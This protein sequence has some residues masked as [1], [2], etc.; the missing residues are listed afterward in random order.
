MLSS[1]KLR[2]LL[3]KLG[4]SA[5]DLATMFIESELTIRE[6]CD[7]LRLKVDIARETALEKI[8]KESN[9]LMSEIDAYEHECWSSW[10]AAKEST[11]VIVEDV[12]KRMRAFLA[13]QHAYLQSV[14]SSDEELTALHLDEASKLAQEL[15]DR[16]KELKAAMFNDKLASFITF[17]SMAEASLLGELSFT[18]I[19]LPFKKLDISTSGLKAVDNRAHFDFLLPLEHGER[20]VAFEFCNK[21]EDNEN[22][23][24]KVTC[25]DRLIRTSRQVRIVSGRVHRRNV[26]QCGPS[27][28][29]VC[30]SKD[31]PELIV[32]DSDLNCLRNVRCK[33]FR[34]I[35]C[36]SKFVFGLWEAINETDSEKEEFSTDRIQVLHLDTLSEAFELRALKKYGMFG[37]VTDE[38]HLIAIGLKDID[39]LPWFMSIFDLA[40][41]NESGGDNSR[42]E[43]TA[44]KFFL[45]ERYVD[46]GTQWLWR[47]EAFLLDGWLVV[48]GENRSTFAWF[49]K[50]GKRSETSTDVDLGNVRAIYWSGGSSLLF[51][52]DDDKLLLKRF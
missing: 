12:R 13:E 52:F 19:T 42:G 9:T 15:S 23:F 18:D 29:V 48:P 31:S 17:T 5:S 21:R 32:Y 7:S 24:M 28:F 3:A 30:L 26:A 44:R 33:D 36:N 1:I 45:A 50:K 14:K 8:H 35:C 34:G 51:A 6:H 2:S 16:K 43:E 22:D 39:P 37:I 47:T 4:D 20:I 46:F 49:D 11:E 38:H 40:T 25:F 10:T 41:C 27:E